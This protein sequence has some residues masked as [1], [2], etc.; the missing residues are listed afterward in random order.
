[1][2]QGEHKSCLHPHSVSGLD[3]LSFLLLRVP[4][5]GGIEWNTSRFDMGKERQ[6]LGYMIGYATPYHFNEV[7]YS[8]ILPALLIMCRIFFSD[9]FPI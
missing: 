7:I 8:C 9:H 2:V 3:L 1:M 6:E 4:G 5:Y